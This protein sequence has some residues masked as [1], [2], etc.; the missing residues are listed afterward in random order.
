MRG[1][2]VRSYFGTASDFLDRR[3]K[4]NN[5]KGMVLAVC[6]FYRSIQQQI[7]KMKAKISL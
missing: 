6:A 1:S 5:H 7:N 2:Y 4:E 3:T